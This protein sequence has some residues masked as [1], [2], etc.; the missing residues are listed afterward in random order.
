LTCS[1][2]YEKE[3]IENDFMTKPPCKIIGII[4]RLVITIA[5]LSFSYCFILNNSCFALAF[6]GV[7]WVELYNYFKEKRE[8]QQFPF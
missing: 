7:W 3:S 6:V 5:Y 1:I 4:Q 8:L 2:I